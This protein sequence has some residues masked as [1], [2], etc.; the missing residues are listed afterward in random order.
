MKTVKSRRY[1]KR[2]TRSRARFK[3]SGDI[4]QSKLSRKKDRSSRRHRHKRKMVMRGGSGDEGVGKS[5]F[6][7]G[8]PLGSLS[9]YGATGR[10]I[11]ETTGDTLTLNL[12]AT[13]IGSAAGSMEKL[14]TA[15]ENAMINGQ[16]LGEF[17]RD[18]NVGDLENSERVKNI[19]AKMEKEHA[20]WIESHRGLKSKIAKLEAVLAKA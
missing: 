15:I 17:S 8:E 18:F 1:R 10:L 20:P 16:T 7:A 12:K 13:P 19:W 9:G 4:K 11:E 3:G 5:N 14:K 6:A 2:S